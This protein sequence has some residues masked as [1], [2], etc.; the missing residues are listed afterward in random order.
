MFLFGK[1]PSRE[2]CNDEKKQPYFYTFV[3]MVMQMMNLL[4]VVNS[5]Q[6]KHKTVCLL[7]L[8]YCN[9]LWFKLKQ[10]LDFYFYFFK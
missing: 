2:N 8:D 3:I 4:K 6:T 5:G 1:M 7:H 10:C 9:R